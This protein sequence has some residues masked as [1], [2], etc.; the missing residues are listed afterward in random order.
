M[1]VHASRRRSLAEPGAVLGARPITA[2]RDTDPP[3]E[4]TRLPEGNL[5]SRWRGSVA[6]DRPTPAGAACQ[7]VL[8]V[9]RDGRSGVRQERRLRR[10][11]GRLWASSGGLAS[12]ARLED[13]DLEELP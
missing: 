6:T 1:T 11:E 3:E 7:P 9:R 2:R 8:V 12:F 13:V 4:N 5:R 10:S